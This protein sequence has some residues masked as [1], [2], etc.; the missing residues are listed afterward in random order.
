[1][2]ESHPGSAPLELRWN[3]NDGQ[4][5]RFRSRSLTITATP[6]ILSDLRAILGVDRVR[7]VRTGS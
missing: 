5:I 6:V 4:P 1:M 3:E 2:V 7:L